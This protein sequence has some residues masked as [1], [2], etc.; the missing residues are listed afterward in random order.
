MEAVSSP[1]EPSGGDPIVG[2]ISGNQV[3]VA[4]RHVDLSD[5]SGGGRLGKQ[6]SA[7]GMF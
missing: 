7:Q 4:T 1:H 6:K 2:E 5:I 3:R